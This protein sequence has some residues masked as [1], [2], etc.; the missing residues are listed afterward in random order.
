MR[1]LL[2]LSAVALLGGCSTWAPYSLPPARTQSVVELPRPAHVLAEF[3]GV[4]EGV[5]RAPSSE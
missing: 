3:V 5:L 1:T 4:M 2:L